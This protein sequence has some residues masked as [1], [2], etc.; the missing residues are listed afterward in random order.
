MDEGSVEQIE[1]TETRDAIDVPLLSAPRAPLPEV[2]TTMSALGD[3]LE[4]LKSGSGDIALDAERASGF[5][6]SQRAYLIQ[7]FRRGG[8]LHLIDPIALFHDA[9]QFSEPSPFTELNHIIRKAEVVI[10]ASSQDLPCLREVGI[11]PMALFDTELAGR[12]AGFPRVGLGALTESLLN[13]RL[14]KEHSAVDWS[15]RPLHRDWLIYA[16][17]DVDVL[18]DLKDEIVRVLTEKKNWS[19]RF[20]SL[21]RLSMRNHLC[22]EKSRGAA[23]QESTK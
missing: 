17:L 6:Y 16:A 22:L 15:L 14:A 12:I 13:I 21:K 19:G 9:Q 11:E 10:H 5:K 2:I 1:A 4:E 20:K 3:A 23:L 18:L 8:G 7:I